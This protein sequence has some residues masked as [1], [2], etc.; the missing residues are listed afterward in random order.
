MGILSNLFS[1]GD[2]DSGNSGDLISNVTGAV[3]LDFTTE[4]YSHD[5]DEDGSESTNWDSTSLS[6]DLDLD[7]I[8][9][10]MTDNFSSSDGDSGGGLFG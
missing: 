5:V 3:G 4:S 10:G 7:S 6:T 2:S 1:S 9:A 8:L